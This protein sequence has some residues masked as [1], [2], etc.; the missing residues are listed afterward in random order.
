VKD[1]EAG[2]QLVNEAIKLVGDEILMQELKNNIVKLGMR[3]A[4]ETIATEILQSIYAS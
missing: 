4:D 3:D 2:T 1:T